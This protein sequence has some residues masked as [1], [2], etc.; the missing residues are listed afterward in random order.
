MSVDSFD[1]QVDDETVQCAVDAVRD[2]C[3]VFLDGYGS[4]QAELKDDGSPVT[5][6][7][8][9]IEKSIVSKLTEDFPE[10]EVIG[11]EFSNSG[12]EDSNLLWIIDP[13]DGT[14]NYEIGSLDSCI[15]I[16][17]EKNGEIFGGVIGLPL[18]STICY[19]TIAEGAYLNEESVSVLPTEDLNRFVV[20]AELRPVNLRTDGYKKMIDTVANEAQQIRCLNSGVSD[21]AH[22]ATGRLHASYNLQASIWDVAAPT[23]LVRA[24]GGKVTTHTGSE[25]WD[26]IKQGYAL[27]SNGVNHDFFTQFF[28]N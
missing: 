10:S 11:E 17:I 1:V 5:K 26:D 18:E 23:A 6:Y 8:K 16:G 7:D 14:A 27:Y 24:A 9:E 25:D 3:E 2:V 19:G 20:G 22:I 15:G 4:A 28:E 12:V 13:I 21:G